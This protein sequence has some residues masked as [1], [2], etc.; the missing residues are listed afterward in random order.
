[1]VSTRS[2]LP[3][4]AAPR[5]M[6][7]RAAS[8]SK[9]VVPGGG[10]GFGDGGGGGGEFGDAFGGCMTST[11][12]GG[13]GT[14]RFNS[15]CVTSTHADGG[16][17]FRGFHHD[18]NGSSGGSGGGGGAFSAAYSGSGTSLGFGRAPVA[19]PRAGSGSNACVPT[20]MAL[21]RNA[22]MSIDELL[23]FTMDT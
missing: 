11:L 1:M 15:G 18:N 19:T 9:L 14:G 12:A 23:E 4:T 22:D 5:L 20:A 17:R 21:K 16:S 6:Q 2:E 7:R 3:L 8:L 10:D 13:G